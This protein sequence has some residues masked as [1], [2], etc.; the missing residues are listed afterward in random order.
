MECETLCI[1]GISDTEHL[2]ED[3]AEE[4]KKDE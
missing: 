4:P 2:E 1:W 3:E